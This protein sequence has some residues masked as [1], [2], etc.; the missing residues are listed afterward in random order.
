MS[1]KL[2]VK[3]TNKRFYSNGWHKFFIL[4]ITIVFKF[5]LPWIFTLFSTYCVIICTWGD[6]NRNINYNVRN[7]WKWKNN[8]LNWLGP[9]QKLCNKKYSYIVSLSCSYSQWCQD[10][11]TKISLDFSFK[12]DWVL[13]FRK[14]PKRVHFYIRN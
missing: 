1:N 7:L 6:W 5:D 12:Y 9:I 3:V 8:L 10:D 2:E 11:L 14:E 13:L 4:L